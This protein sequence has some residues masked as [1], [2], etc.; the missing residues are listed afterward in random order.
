MRDLSDI[1]VPTLVDLQ[2]ID[3]PNDT[4]LIVAQSGEEIPFY[5]KRNYL[6]VTGD[7]TQSRGAHAH[8]KI[9]AVDDGIA[10]RGAN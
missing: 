5:V 2:K 10:W 6:V 7:K 9:M 4:C 8:K 3:G 1:T